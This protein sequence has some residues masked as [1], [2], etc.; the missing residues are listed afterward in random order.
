MHFFKK[1]LAVFLAVILLFCLSSCSEVQEDG[2]NWV[3]SEITHKGALCNTGYYYLSRDFM[4]HYVDFYSGT[5]VCLCSKIACQ[6][7]NSSECEAYISDVDGSTLRY[8]NGGLYYVETDQYGFHLYRR[9][10]TGGDLQKV[11]SLCESYR[12]TYK[13]ISINVFSPTLADGF[14]YYYAEISKSTRSDGVI[15]LEYMLGAILRLDLSTGEETV[16]VENWN[17]QQ[18]QLNLIAAQKNN[19][20]YSLVNFP[21]DVYA[22][23]YSELSAQCPVQLFQWDAASNASTKL[24]EKTRAE[25]GYTHHYFSGKLYYVLDDGLYNYNLQNGKTAQVAKGQTQQ[26]NQDYALLWTNDDSGKQCLLNLNT[27]EQLPNELE[28]LRIRSVSDE[29]VIFWQRI[30]QSERQKYA[31]RYGFVALDSLA[32]GLQEEDFFEFYILPLDK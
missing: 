16:V 2:N 29:F 28:S 20:L 31:R 11:A 8:W 9:N 5:N 7:N 4:L 17:V 10:E 1:G 26:I 22:E 32:D 25:F 6:H 27:N 30:Y 24:L 23:D 18:Q 13:D 14:L 12:R 15:N 19:V 21:E 3:A